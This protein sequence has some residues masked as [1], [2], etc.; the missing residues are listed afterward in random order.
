M[1]LSNRKQ[2]HRLLHPL[3]FHSI[4]FRPLSTARSGDS[5][6]SSDATKEIEIASGS[7]LRRALRSSI[8]H[9]ASIL[10]PSISDH[11]P[12]I[13][14][15]ISSS[16]SHTT[17]GLIPISILTP[18]APAISTSHTTYSHFLISQK[19]NILKRYIGFPRMKTIPPRPLDAMK[20]YDLNKFHVPPHEILDT[21][22][23]PQGICSLNDL[24][25]KLN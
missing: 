24:I 25:V 7:S 11:Q 23:T 19:C 21:D 9:S 2:L 15:T 14:S 10:T 22:L 20:P 13:T 3:L 18:Y 12:T 6:N 4:S 16:I 1:S 5:N 17:R 8:P